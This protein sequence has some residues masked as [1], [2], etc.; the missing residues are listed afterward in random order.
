M[1]ARTPC[2]SFHS[3]IDL[4]KIRLAFTEKGANPVDPTT[5]EKWGMSFASTATRRMNSAWVSRFASGRGCP[6]ENGIIFPDRTSAK[7]RAAAQ[8]TVFRWIRTKPA[9]PPIDINIQNADH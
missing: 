1:C 4:R 3:S 7:P 6:L 8:G 9:F 5:R 2:S